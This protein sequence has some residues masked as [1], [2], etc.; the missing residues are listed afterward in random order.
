MFKIIFSI[1]L[2]GAIPFSAYAGN[3][4]CP[5]DGDWDYCSSEGKL[6]CEDGSVSASCT[7]TNIP[8]P[9]P[10][11]MLNNNEAVFDHKLAKNPARFSRFLHDRVE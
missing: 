2:F 10:S 3:G 9:V 6:Y 7:C 1:A 11:A 4:C 8:D 5:N